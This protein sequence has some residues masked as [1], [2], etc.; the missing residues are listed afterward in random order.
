MRGVGRPRRLT[1]EELPA[2]KRAC[3][4]GMA[5]QELM[6]QFGLQSRYTVYEYK[7]RVGFKAAGHGKP[8][9]DP[10]PTVFRCAGCGGVSLGAPAHPNCERSVA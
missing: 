4:A 1:E 7:C 10:E 5:V 6:R 9:P 3:E 2:F 8:K